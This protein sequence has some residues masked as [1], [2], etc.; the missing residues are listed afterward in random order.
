MSEAVRTE[1]GAPSPLEL[2]LREAAAT[3]LLT[4]EAEQEL[5]RRVQAARLAAE[6]LQRPG[7]TDEQRPRLEA[8]V[9]AG[10]T[11]RRRFVEANQ[12]LV[13]SIAR[14]YRG[15]GLDLEDLVQ[16]GNVGLL[17]AI[18]RF[19]PERGLRF[20]TYALWWIKQA[21]Q[22]AL[23]DHG[24]PIRLPSHAADEAARLWRMADRLAAESGGAPDAAEAAEAAG[25][26]PGRVVMLAR[27]MLRPLSLEAA[28]GDE[29]DAT[30]EDLIPGD[31]EGPEQA[32]ERAAVADLVR[33]GLAQLPERA[34]RVLELRFGLLDES[35]RT[36]VD[37]GE[38]LGISRERARQLEADG[39]RRLRQALRPLRP[40]L[41][42]V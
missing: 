6:E 27:A 20:S 12:R 17:R 29:G 31:E 7:I 2:L 28:V 19:E 15:R 33:H 38:E 21:I 10:E 26:Q 14:R 32:L 9:V 16:E 8:V 30:L 5:G 39:L 3:P 37:V 23:D 34:R 4:A 42:N 11:A 41:A 22:R 25:L 1:R 40:L 36:L 18:E 24:R 35:P 13:V